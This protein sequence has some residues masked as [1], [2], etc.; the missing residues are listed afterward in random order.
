MKKSFIKVEK[1]LDKQAVISY[2]YYIMIVNLTKGNKMDISNG[3]TIDLSEKEYNVLV[4]TLD[5]VYRIFNMF[6][7]MDYDDGTTEML[8]VIKGIHDDIKKVS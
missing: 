5:Q 4:S 8:G 7:N 1:T 3:V 6:P 2:L